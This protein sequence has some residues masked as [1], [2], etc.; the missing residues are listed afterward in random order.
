SQSLDWTCLVNMPRTKSLQETSEARSALAL[1]VLFRSALDTSPPTKNL[2]TRSSASMPMKG[3]EKPSSQIVPHLREAQYDWCARQYAA[4]EE[5]YWSINLRLA[6][7]SGCHGI[8]GPQGVRR[9][10]KNQ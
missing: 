2:P 6:A 8:E 10:E 1:R 5:N 4:G 9:T 3:V 7:E